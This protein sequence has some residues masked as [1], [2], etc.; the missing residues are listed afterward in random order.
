MNHFSKEIESIISGKT[1]KDENF[2]VSSFLIS[3]KHRNH[4]FNLY[5]FARVSDDIADNK[6][7]STREKKK[8]LTEFDSILRKK[9]LSNHIFIN[10]LIRSIKI[11]HN[12]IKYPR[13]LLVAFKQDSEK[14]RYKNWSELINYCSYS[15][16]PIGRYVVDLHNLKKKN[17]NE[18]MKKIYKGC[19]NLCNCLQILNHI[20][21]CKEDFEEMN[22]VYI[23]EDYFKSSKISIEKMLIPKNRKKIL[24]IFKKCLNKVEVLLD[25]SIENIKLIND[26]RLKRETYVIFNI[27]KKLTKLLINND[28]IKKKIKLSHIDL[29]FCFF[30]GIVGRL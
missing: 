12:D 3:K 5:Y 16:S 27:A 18:V 8:L 7:L 22:R 19:D 29:F 14:N 26:Y 6:H 1:M 24:M 28:P 4:I 20:Q 9:S 21:D 13:N 10:N 17:T 30:K 25:D 15:A 11:T 2:P 23:P